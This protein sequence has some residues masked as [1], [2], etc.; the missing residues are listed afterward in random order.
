MSAD[1]LLLDPASLGVCPVFLDSC[2][3]ES[4]QLPLAVFLV[5][6]DD[7]WVADLAVVVVVAAA[8]HLAVG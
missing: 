5:V 3:F 6:A 1:T 2:E 8:V 4:C 7:G